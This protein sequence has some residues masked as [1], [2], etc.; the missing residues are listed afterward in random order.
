MCL[1]YA[2]AI[3]NKIKRTQK[4]HSLFAKILD[5]LGE[6]VRLTF[7]AEAAV[8]SICAHIFI[9]FYEKRGSL[10]LLRSVPDER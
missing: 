5:K 6:H 4:Y 7:F 2:F 3:Q 8:I 10:S 9:N 1:L